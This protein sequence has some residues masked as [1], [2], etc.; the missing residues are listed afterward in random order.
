M[1]AIS[2]LTD[3]AD[4]VPAS[5]I[6]PRRSFA[7]RETTRKMRRATLVAC[8][9]AVLGGV[10]SGVLVA[11]GHSSI[12]FVFP[13]L[14]LPV[15]F[16]KWKE[17]GVIVVLVIATLIEQVYYTVGPGVSGTFTQKIPLFHSITQGSGVN[18]FEVILALILLIWVMKG[19]LEGTLR[20]PHSPLSKCIAIFMGFVVVGIGI[21]LSHGGQ[22]RWIIWEIRPFVYLAAMFWLTASVLTTKRALRA[23][24][25]TLV[26]GSGFKAIQGVLIWLPAR[27]LTPRPEAILSHEEAFFFGLFVFLTL[28]LWIFE[29]RGALRTTATCLLPV[30]L[31]ANLANSRRNSWAVLA[32]GLFVMLVIAYAVLPHRRPL[33][34][35]LGVVLAIGSAFYFPAFWNSSGTI[36]Q[37]ARAVHSA[38]TPDP[39][40]FDSNLYRQQ[41]DANLQFNIRQSHDLGLGFGVPIDYALPIN[42]ISD[43]DPMIAY[44]PHNGVLYIW[45]RLGI[46][47]EAAF[48]L[49]IASAIFRAVQ[50]AK[51]ADQELAFFGTL[52][53]C[54]VL[55]YLVQGYNDMGFTWF[56]IALC[57]GVLFGATEAALRMARRPEPLLTGVPR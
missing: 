21:G 14:L 44:V 7:A 47:G 24:L 41:E 45:M 1:T 22:F 9:L 52:V 15:A 3:T 35:R 18:P 8:A 23:V 55:A 27:H 10:L 5:S 36:G 32:L 17:A 39:R 30:V 16:W 29:M 46:L 25:W 40:D 53:V 43:T 57:M 28:G 4:V 13:A 42:N 2:T 50:L 48:I 26:I 54:A 11:S 37:P 51:V 38:F 56:R 19:A 20:L 34:R 31:L 12:V 6:R 49:M 33:L